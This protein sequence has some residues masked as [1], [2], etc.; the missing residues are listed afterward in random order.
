MADLFRFFRWEFHGGQPPH[1]RSLSGKMTGQA[2]AMREAF[3][4]DIG[5]GGHLHV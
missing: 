3:R 2:C 4:T 5:N 1:P